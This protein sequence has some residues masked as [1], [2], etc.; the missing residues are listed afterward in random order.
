M[1]RRKRTTANRSYCIISPI[2][3]MS[4]SSHHPSRCLIARARKND[5]VLTQL[6]SSFP[7]SFFLYI[8]FFYFLVV[9]ASDRPWPIR[10]TARLGG[11]GQ[12]TLSGTSLAQCWRRRDGVDEKEDFGDHFLT[13]AT[14]G[15]RSCEDVWHEQNKK[16][17]FFFLGVSSS[18][19]DRVCTERGLSVSNLLSWVLKRSVPARNAWQVKYSSVN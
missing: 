13:S 11:S 14:S 19:K 7:H 18:G 5:W 9:A 3:S 16:T 15:R 6:P 10:R 4:C 1:T 12:S 17:E 8:F 2:R